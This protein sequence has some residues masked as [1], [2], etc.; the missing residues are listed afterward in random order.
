[1]SSSAI[2]G[3]ST[4]LPSSVTSI[5]MREPT[6]FQVYGASKLFGV[7]CE[8]CGVASVGADAAAAPSSCLRECIAKR[9]APTATAATA[10]VRISL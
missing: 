6:C 8:A 7:T 4:E 1:M 10:T 9:T 2:D 3:T 5:S